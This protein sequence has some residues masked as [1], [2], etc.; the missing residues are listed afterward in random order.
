MIIDKI[1]IGAIIGISFIVY[2][3]LKT[4][5]LRHYTESREEIDL[6][7][8]RAEYVKELVP[9]V[10]DNSKDVLFRAHSLGALIET[11]S[12]APYSA[13]NF[14]QKILL[15][16]VLGAGH[17]NVSTSN[18]VNGEIATY[19]IESGTSSDYFEDV[20]FKTMPEGLPAILKEY[21]L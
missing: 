10:V 18:P 4:K 19:S 2:D 13:I 21:S 17:F 7:F 16:D 5:E 6:G 1:I 12:I 9:I 8:K 11:K 14:A 15:S 3:N 20:I